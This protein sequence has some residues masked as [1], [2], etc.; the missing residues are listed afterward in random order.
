M[1]GAWT[2]KE[3]ENSRKKYGKAVAPCSKLVDFLH[4]ELPNVELLTCP[5]RFQ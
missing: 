4:L 1:P 5:R 3:E 2:T